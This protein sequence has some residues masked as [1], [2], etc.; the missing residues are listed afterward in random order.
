M[1]FPGGFMKRLCTICV[2]GGSKGVPG[3]NIR[4][5]GG[6]PLVAHSIDQARES[7]LFNTVAISSDAEEIL[8]VARRWKAD[9][10]IRRPAELAS[11]RAAKVDAIQHCTLEAER[12]RG[13]QFDEIVDIDATSPLRT[14]DDIRGAVRL[15]E[16]KRPSNV[17]SAMPARRS[18]YFNLVELDD[19]GF[20]HLSKKPPSQP[21]VRRQDSPP[22]FDLN[23]SI[24]VWSRESL[25]RQR[26]IFF[27]DTMLYVMPEE[28][29]WDIDT[30]VDFEIVNFLY[31]KTV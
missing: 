6:K 16:E 11:D 23:A 29:S 17:V 14:P 31:Q 26:S 21:I 30:E 9:V 3:K 13:V 7:G 2:R 27:P 4:M 10:L 5:L 20:A 15:F 1:D 22:C 12:S 24:I 8:E 18:P 28:R 25:F 19:K